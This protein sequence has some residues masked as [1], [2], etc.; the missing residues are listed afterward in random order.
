MNVTIA[1]G[2]K[3]VS[4]LIKTGEGDL[5]GLII[6]GLNGANGTVDL[7]DNTSDADGTRLIPQISFLSLAAQNEMIKQILFPKPVH[8]FNGCYL[9]ITTISG[10]INVEVYTS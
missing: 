3:T 5:D 4:Y 1:S 7:Y 2:Q 8:F 10:A 9:K 6:S